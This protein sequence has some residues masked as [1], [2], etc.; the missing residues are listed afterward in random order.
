MAEDKKPDKK[1]D[2][3]PSLEKLVELMAENNRS[4]YE[5]ERDGRNT[6][7]H[8][9]EMKKL[10]QA[11]LDMSDSIST[12]FD[13]FFESMNA[14]KLGDKEKASER[15]SIF[16]EIREEIKALG[17][18]LNSAGGGDSG[19]GGGGLLK[20][21]GK[22]LS[23]A[24]IGVGAAAAG[25]AAVFASSSFLLDKLEDMDAKK[26]VANVVELVSLNDA[27]GGKA[28]A[29]K[30]GGALAGVLSG[31]ALGL[32]AFSVGSGVSAL[33]QGAIEKFELTGW[34]ERIKENVGTLLSI[35]ELPGFGWDAGGVAFTMAGLGLGLLAFSAGQASGVAVNK[36]AMVAALDKFEGY[37]RW[38][39]NIK[40]NMETLLSIKTRSFSSTIGLAGTMAALGFGLLVFSAGQV[41]GVAVE[42]MT[43]A[44]NKFEGS[45]Y[46]SENIKKNVETLVSIA[47][48]SFKDAAKVSAALG[49]LGFGL[50]AFAAGGAA[51]A[52]VG[53][54]DE[55]V[56]YFSEM[57]W[58]Y[59]VV[60][61]VSKLAEIGEDAEN[62]TKSAEA[63]KTLGVLGL[64]LLAFGAGTWVG[65][66]GTASA[67]LINFFV[68]DK[69]P[70]EQALLIG[71]K[72][73]EIDKGTDAFERFSDVLRKFDKIATTNFDVDKF[74][75]DMTKAAKTL[76]LVIMGGPAD[77]GWFEREV[78][79]TGLS[80]MTDDVDAAV[81][82]IT[83]LEGALNM[84]TGGVAVST[85]RQSIGVELMNVSA[86]NVILRTSG[87]E[88]TPSI[89]SLQDN[90]SVNKG[91]DTINM[92]NVKPSKT[93][94]SI[95]AAWNWN[96]ANFR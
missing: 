76:E 57:G 6:R 17:N 80:N 66:L 93:Q 2:K 88:N 83:R 26:I 73:K 84:T 53:G 52:A 85:D 87:R 12:G 24:G 68:G 14:N 20:G 94:N 39:E 79:Y 40:T 19:G 72:S 1:P 56:K 77:A 95:E 74:A 44:L 29:L 5:I 70:I 91:G 65:A 23:G 47:D 31:I 4:T 67:A 28:E 27:L 46:W 69:S 92:M 37:N 9:L 8:L 33:T 13:N 78:T 3:T 96:M 81:A 38:S 58:S 89:T 64:G 50:V 18:S 7:R 90:S 36:L 55:G 49:L 10:Q 61:N 63:A 21:A 41:S 34:T 35:Y 59:R 30:N 43:A 82:N 16:E 15:A 45:S 22:L 60:A 11:S 62:L 25:V 48:L 75:A 42:G 71:E 86:E 32:L 51:N 54:I